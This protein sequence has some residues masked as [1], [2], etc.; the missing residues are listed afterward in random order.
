MKEAWG[1]FL[2][3]VEQISKNSEEECY[4]ALC[5]IAERALDRSINVIVRSKEEIKAAYRAAVYGEI[6]LLFGNILTEEDAE[7][8]KQRA[9]LAFRELLEEK[10]EF[11]G[12]IPKGILIDTPLA[13]LTALP[14]DGI[15]FFCY[16]LEKLTMLLTKEKKTAQTHR[17]RIRQIIEER[18][19]S[20]RPA[21]TIETKLPINRGIWVFGEGI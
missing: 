7:E 12:F 19:T 2:A 18:I 9:N 5:A 21:K 11:N 8:A 15:D 1:E 13:L 16:D 3:D 14:A 6:S 4:E 10:H 17:Q 20:A